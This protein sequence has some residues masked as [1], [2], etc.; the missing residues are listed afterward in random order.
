MKFSVFRRSK[1]IALVRRF[2]KPRSVLRF[3]HEPFVAIFDED[4]PL[5]GMPAK[6]E[7]VEANA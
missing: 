7:H 5:A 4:C 1:A 2:F 3:F 6:P